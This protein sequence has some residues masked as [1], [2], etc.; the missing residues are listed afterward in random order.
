MSSLYYV[1]CRITLIY[2]V[3]SQYRPCQR[4]D[5]LTALG[6]ASNIVQFVDFTSKIISATH[7]LYRSAAGAKTEHSEL[8]K[9]A[10]SLRS[11]A[12]QATP[13]SFQK[14]KSLSAEDLALIELGELC[15]GVS[16]ELLCV[17]QSL[18]V[19]GSKRGWKSFYQALRSEWKQRE[20]AALQIRLDR[21]G[22]VLSA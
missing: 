16:D 4:M 10:K 11:L 7:S 2:T 1:G 8:E 3:A 13:P 5:P 21:I 12:D 6:L 14:T 15:R 19:K 20:I 17:L 18:K 9:V 22:G